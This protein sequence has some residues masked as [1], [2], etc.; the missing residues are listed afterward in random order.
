MIKFTCQYVNYKLQL[1]VDMYWT[2]KEAKETNS[3]RD[4]RRMK[5]V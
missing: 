4:S 5:H 1:G 3:V 2:Y